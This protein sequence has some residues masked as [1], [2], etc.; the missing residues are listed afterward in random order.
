MAT[1]NGAIILTGD[2]SGLSAASAEARKSIDS[3][4]KSAEQ[5]RQRIIASYEA[6]MKAAVEAGESQRQLAF[7]TRQYTNIAANV[8]EESAQRSIN[9]VEKLES[10][11][12]RYREAAASLASPIPPG[13]P[14]I[15]QPVSQFT[16]GGLL[17]ESQAQTARDFA[18][19]VEGVNEAHTRGI[20]PAVKFGSVLRGTELNFTRNIRAAE[21]F[22]SSLTFLGPIIEGAFPVVGAATLVYALYEMGKNAYDAFQ[23]IV[24]LKGAMEELNALRIDTDKEVERDRDAVESSVEAILAK[25]KGAAASLG[26]KYGYQSGKDVDISSLFYSD[27]FKKLPDSVK[28]NFEETYKF[29]AP[30]DLP[31]RLKQITA[32]I[33]GLQ[34]AIAGVKDHSIS[35]FNLPSF[36]GTRPGVLTEP[37]DHYER[38]LE[39]ASQIRDRLAGANEVRTASLQQIQTDQESAKAEAIKKGGQDSAQAQQRNLAQ[40]RQLWADEIVEW[41]AAGARTNAE[42]AE[43]WAKKAVIEAAGS[44]NFREA[45][46]HA[47]EELVKTIADTT[48]QEVEFRKQVKELG[49]DQSADIAKGPD[50]SNAD[51]S[52]K[53]YGEWIRNLREYHLAVQGSG[54]LAEQTGIQIRVA[55]GEITRQQAAYEVAALHVKEYADA[56]AE[57]ND[58]QAALD[59]NQNLSDADRKAGQSSLDLQ[60]AQLNGRQ[61]VTNME[62][63]ATIAAMSW[64]G[65]FKKANRDWVGDLNSQLS[66]LIAGQGASWSRMF[67]AI[68]QEF[69]HVGLSALESSLFDGS[70]KSSGTGFKGAFASFASF[71][72]GRAIGGGVDANTSYLVGERGPEILTMGSK[73]G[74]I[75]PNSQIGGGSSHYYTID[76]RGATDPAAIEAAVQRGIASAAPSIIAGSVYAVSDTNRRKPSTA[77]R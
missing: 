44:A 60:R 12:L 49:A 14:A 5:A 15:S 9:A 51:A 7:L 24:H 57:I 53:G 19:A 64:S 73:S 10:R 56:L 67:G 18:A 6:Q 26:Q 72:T 61:T 55:N 1:D 3:V 8:T 25:N 23:N 62:D 46:R 4:A 47:N 69:A 74:R 16:F 36:A 41:Q 76:A 13:E 77:P 50:L 40:Q 63:Q 71:L 35:A 22:G 54:Y 39:A 20:P 2:A 38:Q 43:W 75:T 33:N 17:T 32:T 58:Q 31:G 42:I 59:A 30:A 34:A 70:G 65:A 66:D 52:A 45:M 37:L 27:K 29:I 28:G 21:A 68:A 11:I 48:R